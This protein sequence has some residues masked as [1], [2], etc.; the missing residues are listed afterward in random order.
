MPKVKVFVKLK[1][2]V[3]DAQ[4]R[5]IQSALKH[6]GYDNLDQVRIGK[7]IEL[8]VRANGRPLE[9]EV[10]EMCDKLLANPVMEDYD[11]EVSE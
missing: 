2:T 3:L 1:P 4:G 10:R 5:V 9:E 7:Y 8:D 6:L 11:F